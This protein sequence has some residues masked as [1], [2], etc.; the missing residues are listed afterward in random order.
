MNGIRFVSG[1]IDLMVVS[2][3]NFPLIYWISIQRNLASIIFTTLSFVI[4]VLC[5]DALG[6]NIGKRLFRVKILKKGS[7]EDATA[8]QKIIRNIPLIIWPIE[9]II[10]LSS[11][12]GQRLGDKLAHTEIAIGFL[13]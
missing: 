13:K 9:A 12:D 10:L 8:K 4:C 6:L 5:K 3:I 2:L 1:Y 7:L 11:K